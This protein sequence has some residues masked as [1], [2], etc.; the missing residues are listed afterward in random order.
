MKS[1][2]NP[3]CCYSF[4][5]M[6]KRQCFYTAQKKR[7]KQND[8]GVGKK[9]KK[10]REHSTTTKG[11]RRPPI[12]ASA[13]FSPFWPPRI[14]RVLNSF[15]LDDGKSRCNWSC[16]RIVWCKESKSENEKNIDYQRTQKRQLMVIWRIKFLQKSDQVVQKSRV[17]YL[18]ACHCL[19]NICFWADFHLS[20]TVSHRSDSDHSLA[21]CDRENP[22]V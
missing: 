13:Y 11:E 19:E 6:G 1:Q 15:P 12:K 9:R 22:P 4:T 17:E 10:R 2:H 21:S 14:A 18:P 16:S 3:M 20:F 5:E 8:K 7:E